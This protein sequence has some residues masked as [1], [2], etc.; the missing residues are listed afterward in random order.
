MA[1][2]PRKPLP[3][4]DEEIRREF[5][6]AKDPAKQI[7]ILAEENDVS[8]ETIRRIVSEKPAQPPTLSGFVPFQELAE[9]KKEKEKGDGKTEDKPI[10]V[11]FDEPVFLP[12]AL[13]RKKQSDAYTSRFGGF[14]SW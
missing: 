14:D 6:L 3:M 10:R 4:S 12:P 5:R 7:K 11:N 8:R 13:K 2:R 9:Q 1:G